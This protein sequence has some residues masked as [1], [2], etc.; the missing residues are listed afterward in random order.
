[1][2]VLEELI[3]SFSSLPGLGKKSAARIV[4]HLLKTS[5]QYCQ[6]FGS[7][8]NTLHESVKYCDICGSF[9]EGATCTVCNDAGRDKTIV[10]VVEEPQDVGTFLSLPE[11]TGIFHV[12]GGAISPLHGVNPDS[13]NIASLVE[14]VNEGVIK[15]VILATNPT[16]EGDTTALYIQNQLKGKDVKITRLAFGLPVGG[17]L[18]YV[19]RQTLSR[20]LNGRLQF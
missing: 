18:E 20:S 10:C 19:D 4:Y 9:S 2:S 1:M 6:R 12:L 7:L 5:P 16:L 3:S 13:L 11:Y 8:L 14:R 17:E 15:E